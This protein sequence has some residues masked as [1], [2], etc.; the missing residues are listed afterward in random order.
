MPERQRRAHRKQEAPGERV[1]GVVRRLQHGR[2][3]G[4]GLRGRGE[5]VDGGVRRQVGRS[6]RLDHTR[7]RPARADR[8]VEEIDPPGR[9]SAPLLPGSA[10]RTGP[11]LCSSAPRQ[12]KKDRAASFPAGARP[13]FRLVSS[14]AG[15]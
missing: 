12:R 15:G 7:R 9:C 6:F 8:A 5:D 13:I 3:D 2:R 14:A 10:R 11:L 4:G 1:Q